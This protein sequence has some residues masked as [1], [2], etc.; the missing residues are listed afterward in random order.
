[1]FEGVKKKFRIAKC[2]ALGSLGGALVG[3]F[4]QHQIEKNRAKNGEKNRIQFLIKMHATTSIVQ[5]MI[6]DA[7]HNSK[8]GNEAEPPF[9]QIQWY[10]EQIIKIWMADEYIDHLLDPT[11]C[12]D[13]DNESLH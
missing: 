8:E 9:D 11:V 3:A 2:A 5:G 6:S 7:Y 10:G 1:M 13:P 12:R 4:G